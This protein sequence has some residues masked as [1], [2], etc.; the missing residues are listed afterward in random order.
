MMDNGKKLKTSDTYKGVIVDVVCSKC[1]RKMGQK[2]IPEYGS[3][4]EMVAHRDY[5]G[6]CRK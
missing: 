2:V 3:Y 5:C 1:C 6:E 4:F